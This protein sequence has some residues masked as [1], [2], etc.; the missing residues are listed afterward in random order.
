MV[1]CLWFDFVRYWY[2]GVVFD[3]F[4]CYVFVFVDFFWC[5][6]GV[7]GGGDDLFGDFCCVVECYGFGGG[8]GVWWFCCVDFDFYW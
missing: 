5:G 8:G 7:V 1:C 2:C 4:C 3:Y 6:V